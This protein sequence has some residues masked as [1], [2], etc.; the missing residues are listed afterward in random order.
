MNSENITIENVL[1]IFSDFLLS[2]P[3]TSKVTELPSA[4]N[5]SGIEYHMIMDMG[6]ISMS[7]Y[8]EGIPA[9]GKPEGKL[10]TDFIGL[11]RGNFAR[12][13]GLADL[14]SDHIVFL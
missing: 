13:E 9:F 8:D 4:I 6:T 12:F 14:V 7:R 10:L 3:G 11:L 2:N 5:R 1:E